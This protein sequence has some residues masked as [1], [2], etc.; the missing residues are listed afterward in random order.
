[1][2]DAHLLSAVNVSAP[3]RCLRTWRAEPSLFVQRSQNF[4]VLA[5]SCQEEAKDLLR[6]H[7]QGQDITVI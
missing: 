7:R 4:A 5:S 3:A 6:G 2:R 1:M